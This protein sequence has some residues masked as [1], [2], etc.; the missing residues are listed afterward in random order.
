LAWAGLS[1]VWFMSDGVH[2]ETDF[3]VAA[4]AAAELDR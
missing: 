1:A 4:L 2:P 3:A